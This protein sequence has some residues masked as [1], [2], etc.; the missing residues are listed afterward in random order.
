MDC[1]KNNFPD[2]FDSF[3]KRMS[4]KVVD[5]YDLHRISELKTLRPLQ[6]CIDAGSILQVEGRLENAELPLDAKHPIIL[7]S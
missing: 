4:E 5:V 2:E 7:P 3:L 6:L 1:L